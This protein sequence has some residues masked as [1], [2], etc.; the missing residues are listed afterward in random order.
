MWTVIEYYFVTMLFWLSADFC[1]WIYVVFSTNYSNNHRLTAWIQSDTTHFFTKQFKNGRRMW[2]C[3]NSWKHII[4][5]SFNNFSTPNLW[6]VHRPTSHTHAHLSNHFSI[7]IH[8]HFLYSFWLLLTTVWL[9]GWVSIQ[10]Y[11]ATGKKKSRTE[12]LTARLL[13]WRFHIILR[14]FTFLPNTKIFVDACF[15]W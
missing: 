12:I 9:L 11:R 14:H 10:I 1:E 4:R 2:L 5:F 13:I 7:F 8:Q 15:C 3:M 6:S